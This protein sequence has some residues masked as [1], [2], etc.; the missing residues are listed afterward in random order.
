M[1]VASD[2]PVPPQMP[3]PA[4][5]DFRHAKT[6]PKGYKDT[7]KRKLDDYAEQ[8]RLGTATSAALH[9]AAGECVP[10]PTLCTNSVACLECT[11]RLVACPNALN[12]WTSQV[13][14]DEAEI[15]MRGDE[16]PAANS[17]AA[18][19]VKLANRVSWAV[20]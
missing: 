2:V 7:K 19:R 9:K 10:L 5:Y 17:Q 4:T 20:A 13:A 16:Q 11:W 3:V 18:K 15:A 8:V 6:A 1:A 12:I 14:Q